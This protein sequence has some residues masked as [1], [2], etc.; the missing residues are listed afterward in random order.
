M[1]QKLC[2]IILEI[3]HCFVINMCKLCCSSNY[4]ADMTTLLLF[5]KINIDFSF[6]KDVL[7]TLCVSLILHTIIIAI[8]TMEVMYL[9]LLK[10]NSNIFLGSVCNHKFD[11]VSINYLKLYR[12]KVLIS[13][14]SYYNYQIQN[15]ISNT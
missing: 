13:I 6:L 11:I 3:V 8:I 14:C 7:F 10:S 15:F 4:L 2:P 5:M 12:T 1:T 9:L